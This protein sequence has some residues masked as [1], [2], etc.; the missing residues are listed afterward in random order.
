MAPSEEGF[1]G[2]LTADNCDLLPGP[3]NIRSTLLSVDLGTVID[4][5][6]CEPPPISVSANVLLDNPVHMRK[7]TLLPTIKLKY[8][9]RLSSLSTEMY[10]SDSEPR[11]CTVK[12]PLPQLGG[13]ALN[14]R[15]PLMRTS[16]PGLITKSVRIPASATSVTMYVP[17]AADTTTGKTLCTS[18]PR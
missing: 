3:R 11:S 18:A 9:L 8:T 12:H 4:E 10:V 15:S 2:M 7:L 5:K 14:P 17:A 6:L 13:V 16:C 1:S